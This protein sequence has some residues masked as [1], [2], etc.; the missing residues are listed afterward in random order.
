MNLAH[1]WILAELKGNSA[2]CRNR[3]RSMVSL[4]FV[5]LDWIEPCGQG[6]REELPRLCPTVQ[7]GRAYRKSAGEPGRNPPAPTLLQY[8]HKEE[9]QHETSQCC[10][11]DF[12]SK[13]EPFVNGLFSEMIDTPGQ[14]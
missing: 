13:S 11:A 10:L 6:N 2:F 1:R 9:R 3:D 14:L 5:Q 8:T 7:S 12:I 4:P